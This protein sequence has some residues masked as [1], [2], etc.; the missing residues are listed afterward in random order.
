[1]HD[2][3]RRGGEI[4][5]IERIDAMRRKVA[6]ISGNGFKIMRLIYHIDLYLIQAIQ[7]SS[8]TSLMSKNDA[9]CLS[10]YR[11]STTGK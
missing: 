11:P 9:I 10:E 1:M 4:A 2:L 7:G 6:Y 3:P 5:G 8:L